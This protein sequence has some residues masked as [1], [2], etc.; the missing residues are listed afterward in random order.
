MA[1]PAWL[2]A[3]PV[4]H[5]GLHDPASGIF[6]NTLPAAEAAIGAGYAIEIDV[7]VT[8][9]GDAVV[10]HDWT[11]DRL[12]DRTGPVAGLT[13]GALSRLTIGGGE[14]RIPTLAR[15]LDVLAG[16][17]PVFIELKSRDD[18][19]PDLVAAVARAL[20]GYDGPAAVMSF[21]PRALCHLAHEIPDRPRG[22]VSMRAAPDVTPPMRRIRQF[23]RA[24]LL[25]LGRTRPHFIAYHC[26]DLPVAGVTFARRRG[27]PVLSWTVRSRAEADRIAPYV[28][29][30][31]FED[32]RPESE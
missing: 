25:H 13:A 8:A 32:F 19:A 20:A 3:R 2:T 9:D 15:F 10:F 14:A 17:A 28:D 11:L 23:A 7:Q 4:A 6:E 31:I 24:H 18:G 12:T 29:Q 16:R 30:I 26:K 1:T 21:V 27:L 5:R 22:S